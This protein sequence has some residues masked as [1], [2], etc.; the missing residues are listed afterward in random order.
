VTFLSEEKIVIDVEAVDNASDVI[1]DAS[2]KISATLKDVTV[3]LAGTATAGFNLYNAYDN[4]ADMGVQVDR[5]NLQVKSTANQLADAQ[6]KVNAATEKY[7]VYSSEAKAASADLALAQERHNLA[8]ERGEMLEGNYNETIV[9]SALSVIPSLITMTASLSSIKGILAT[10]TVANTAATAAE[11]TVNAAAVAPT[12]TLTGAVAALNAVLM[13]NPIILVIAAVAALV[14]VLIYAYNACKPFKEAVD[15]VGSAL[16]SVLKP[17]I[18]A[19]YNALKWLW[20]NILKPLADFLGGTFLQYLTL[21]GQAFGVLVNAIS[22]TAYGK[23]Q[24]F[25]ELD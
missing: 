21:V 18:D 10:S 25:P 1:A 15:A 20:D 5:A 4:V 3:S 23:R 11:G 22:S 6:N 9:R 24:G 13:A 8:V 7:G 12:L 2:H 17:A 19:V 16:W 14:G